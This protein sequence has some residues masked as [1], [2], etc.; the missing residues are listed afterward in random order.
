MEEG[1]LRTCVSYTAV[2]PRH[3]S[4]YLQALQEV[5]GEG[6]VVVVSYLGTG[7]G[8]AAVKGLHFRNRFVSGFLTGVGQI[9][10]LPPN[11]RPSGSLECDLIWK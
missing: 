9:V 11:S 2:E 10:S 6:V 4:R 7:Q 5:P 8:A 1:I 3:W